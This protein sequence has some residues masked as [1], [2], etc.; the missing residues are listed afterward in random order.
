MFKKYELELIKKFHDGRF[1][2]Q[3]L[4]NSILSYSKTQNGSLQF[5]QALEGII[6]AK[7][8][9]MKPQELSNIIYSY[10]KS[11]N[12]MVDPLLLD[13]RDTVVANLHRYKPVE[14]C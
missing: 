7:K 11:E 14:L 3:S 8:E 1:S 5:F 10:H 2:T 13:L 9:H 12:A 4:S 6:L